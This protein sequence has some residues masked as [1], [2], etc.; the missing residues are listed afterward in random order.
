MRNL[1]NSYALPLL[2]KI[3]EQVTNMN[4]EYIFAILKKLD[5]DL[6][7]KDGKVL[8]MLTVKNQQRVDILAKIIITVLE[9]YMSDPEKE[10]IRRIT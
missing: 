4:V 3:L 5:I 8:K 2:R 9:E 1:Q 7:S 6:E 10:K